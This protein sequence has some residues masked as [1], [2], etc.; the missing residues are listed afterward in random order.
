M[1]LTWIFVMGAEVL[2]KRGAQSVVRDLLVGFDPVAILLR[3]L[4]ARFGEAATF[5]ADTLGGCVVGLKWHPQVM[6]TSMLF[7]RCFC[8][9]V[10]QPGHRSPQTANH[11]L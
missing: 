9:Q 6:A 2:S 1:R 4:E 8:M 5:C 11:H 7:T 3:T 10:L